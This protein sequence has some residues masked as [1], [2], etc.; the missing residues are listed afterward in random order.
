MIYIYKRYAYIHIEK[1]RQTDRQIDR[2]TDKQTDR[3][4]QTDRQR[5]TDRDRERDR[6]K[7]TNRDRDRER[8]VWK[9][10]GRGGGGYL[11]LKLLFGE[12]ES[13]TFRLPYYII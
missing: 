2:Q 9:K 12:L 6:D 11:F 8:C 1:Q 3:D 10:G 13:Q 4:R 5:Q 7:Q